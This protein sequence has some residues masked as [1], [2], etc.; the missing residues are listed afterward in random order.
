MDISG[1]RKKID[2]IDTAMLQLINLRAELA[3]EVGRLKRDNGIALRARGREQEIVARMKRANP[4]PLDGAAVAKI[5]TLIVKEC[6]NAQRT[7]GFG[8]KSAKRADR[9]RGMK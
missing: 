6:I 3:L 1:W 2:A 7:H 4:G 8:G 5:Y 9:T